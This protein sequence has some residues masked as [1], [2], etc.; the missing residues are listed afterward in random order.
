LTGNV[1]EPRATARSRLWTVSWKK[2][3]PCV[4]EISRRVCARRNH[5]RHRWRQLRLRRSKM[6]FHPPRPADWQHMNYFTTEDCQPRFI[7][8]MP[9]HSCITLRP[10]CLVAKSPLSMR[11]HSR[12]LR[13]IRHVVTTFRIQRRRVVSHGPHLDAQVR[14]CAPRVVASTRR[15]RVKLFRLVRSRD[16]RFNDEGMQSTI[17][18]PSSAQRHPA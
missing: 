4:V 18:R 5:S 16:R 8:T 14:D 11:E 12:S 17:S 1:S 2:G 15:W 9:R 13:L 7:L 10:R 6:A 3:K